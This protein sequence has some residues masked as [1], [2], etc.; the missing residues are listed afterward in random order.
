MRQVFVYFY[1]LAH[2]SG[3][4]RRHLVYFVSEVHLDRYIH[5]LL[6]F[7]LR[8]L[9]CVRLDDSLGTGEPLR[10]INYSV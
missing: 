3:L 1:L 9:L 6:A 8:C 2:L 4:P 7:H 5:E 10:Q